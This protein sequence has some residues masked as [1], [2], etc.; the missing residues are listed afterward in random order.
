MVSGVS[1]HQSEGTVMTSAPPRGPEVVKIPEQ[2]LQNLAN[3]NE[4]IHVRNTLPNRA[5]FTRV[6]NGNLEISEFGPKGDPEGEDVMQLSASYLRDAA[7]SKQLQKGIFEIIDADNPAVIDAFNAQR[8][9]WATQQAQKE[10][11]DM[12]TQAH[13]PKNVSGTDCIAT[14]G[15]APCTE[16]AVYAT[17]YRERPP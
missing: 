11:A 8:A 15:T 6:H 4:Y 7:F 2:N 9:S 1:S 13:L 5:I 17:N 16:R 14:D 3:Q 10:Q 12:I